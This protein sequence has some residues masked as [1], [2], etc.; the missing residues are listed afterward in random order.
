MTPSEQSKFVG[1]VL[2]ILPEGERQIFYAG[3]RAMAAGRL[4]GKDFQ[5]RLEALLERQRA[6]EEITP[7]ELEFPLLVVT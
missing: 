6:G 4:N 5:P 7:E 2:A 3:I 1:E